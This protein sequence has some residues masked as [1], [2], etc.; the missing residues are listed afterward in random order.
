[1]RVWGQST[2]DTGEVKAERVLSGPVVGEAA[3]KNSV[4]LG[5]QGHCLQTFL[6]HRVLGK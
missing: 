6:S 4:R 5:L 3:G 2:E 1:M